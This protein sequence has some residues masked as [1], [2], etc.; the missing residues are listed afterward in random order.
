MSIFIFTVVTALVISFF[1]SLSEAAVLSLTPAQITKMEQTHPALAEIWRGFKKNIDRPISV[2]LFLNTTA[3][4]V[5]ASVAGAQFDEIY[6]DEWIW[7]FSLML[8]F[9]MLQWTELAPKTIGVRNNAAVAIAIGR[10][11]NFLVKILQPLLHFLNL[12]NRPFTRGETKQEQTSM[13]DELSSMAS[14]A[15]LSN[16]ISSDQE[17]IIQSIPK[18]TSKR[19]LDIMIPVEQV[20]FIKAELTIEA[21][22]A[23]AQHDP[24]TRFPVYAAGDRNR[25]TGYVNLKELV[26][27]KSVSPHSSELKPIRP[28]KFVEAHTSARELLKIFIEERIHIAIVREQ[29]TTLGLITMEDIIEEILGDLE[30]EFDRLPRNYQQIADDLWMVGGG[31]TTKEL[32]A[33][34]GTRLNEDTKQTISEW[35]ISQL[36]RIPNTGESVRASKRIFQVKRMRRGKVFE[37][38]VMENNRMPLP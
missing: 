32:N 24:H 16:I 22:L 4:T 25:I 8:T 34:L 30:D 14:Y 26:F 9:V 27:E 2:I 21:A 6:G 18:L 5:G 10:P 29:E 28:V 3:H 7:A 20:V 11:L 15:R 37:L 36:G 23:V 19:A 13:I 35:F 31:V 1:C 17:K 38:A 12:L 33:R